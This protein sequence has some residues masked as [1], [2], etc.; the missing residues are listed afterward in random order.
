MEHSKEYLKA[1]SDMATLEMMFAKYWPM[2]DFNEWLHIPHVYF[3][4]KEPLILIA[5]GKGQKVIT[6]L[7]ACLDEQ[8]LGDLTH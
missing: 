5:Q 8:G 2:R 4:D 7:N 3:G 1:S 6:Y